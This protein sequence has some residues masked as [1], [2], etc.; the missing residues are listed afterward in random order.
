[1]QCCTGCLNNQGFQMCKHLLQWSAWGTHSLT[2][3]SKLEITH[4]SCFFQFSADLTICPFLGIYSLGSL[5]SGH[6]GQSGP[7]RILNGSQFCK[8]LQS[9]W[10]VIFAY[11]LVCS[12]ASLDRFSV[13]V[14]LVTS[15][16]VRWGTACGAIEPNLWISNIVASV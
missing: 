13:L 3:S 10:F 11:I 14:L 7:Q 16:S 8:V 6:S 12:S 4:F 1:M 2:D 5:A 9:P 15:P